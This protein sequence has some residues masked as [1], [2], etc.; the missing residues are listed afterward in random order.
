MTVLI[1][2][3]ALILVFMIGVC[4]GAFTVEDVDG[5][6]RLPAGWWVLPAAVMSGLLT[7]A[8]IVQVF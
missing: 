5:E 7:A 2:T 4:L 8:V 3:S 1:A 6:L